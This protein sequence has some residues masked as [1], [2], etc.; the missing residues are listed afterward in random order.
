MIQK[1]SRGGTCPGAPVVPPPMKSQ[2]SSLSQAC[3]PSRFYLET[4]DFE[5]ILKVSRV[6]LY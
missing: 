2:A 4:Q 3:Q 1:F 6:L 5:P